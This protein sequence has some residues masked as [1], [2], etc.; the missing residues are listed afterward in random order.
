MGWEGVGGVEWVGW[1]EVVGWVGGGRMA[2][3]GEDRERRGKEVGGWGVVRV[4]HP[5]PFNSTFSHPLLPLLLSFPPSS[6]T[7]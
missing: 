1:G 7:F 6:H 2:G 3:V 4:L 5:T